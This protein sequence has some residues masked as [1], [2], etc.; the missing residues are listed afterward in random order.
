MR[1]MFQDVDGAVTI[2][3]VLSIKRIF[4]KKCKEVYDYEIETSK[5]YITMKQCGF[6]TVSDQVMQDLLKSGYASIILE[7][8][9]TIKNK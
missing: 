1:I 4:S 2:E 8:N 3:S 7:K 6:R 9:L 5:H